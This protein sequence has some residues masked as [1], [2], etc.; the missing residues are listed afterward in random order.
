MTDDIH[1]IP[2][3][4]LYAL[5]ISISSAYLVLGIYCWSTT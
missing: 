5:T 4:A 2:N 1:H 3:W